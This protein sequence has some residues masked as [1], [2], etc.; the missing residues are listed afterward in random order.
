VGFDN[1]YVLTQH[2][3]KTAD[4]IQQLYDCGALGKWADIRG[5]KPPADWDG[6]SGLILAREEG[7]M[8]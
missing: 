6:R 8:A 2:L 7:G 4:E 3:G 1:E 5:R